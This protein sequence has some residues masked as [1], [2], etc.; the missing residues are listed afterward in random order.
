[1][2]PTFSRQA[3]LADNARKALHSHTS[4]DHRKIGVD[5]GSGDSGKT[6]S[7]KDLPSFKRTESGRI[8][9]KRNSLAQAFTMGEEHDETENLEMTKGFQKQLDHIAHEEKYLLK[10]GSFYTQ[11]W[12][13]LMIVALIYTA[14]VTPYEIALVEQDG[15]LL[16]ALF[17]TNRLVDFTFLVDMF[18][19]LNLMFFN[20]KGLLVKS[21]RRIR[22]RYLTGWFGIDFI[23]ILP[24]DLMTLN[25]TEEL[26][27]L[28]FLRIFRLLKLLRIL[29]ASRLF[30]DA[31][32]RFGFSTAVTTVFQLMLTLTLLNHWLACIWGMSAMLQPQHVSTWLTVWLDSQERKLPDCQKDS[33]YANAAYRNT[34]RGAHNTPCRQIHSTL[35]TYFIWLICHARAHAYK[36]RQDCHTL[37]RA[38]TEP[39][40]YRLTANVSDIPRDNPN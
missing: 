15:P 6:A 3:S 17:V 10:P 19:S 38:H 5:D 24:Y 9:G 7:I 11:H 40:T 35:S 22:H 29:R 25:S 32:T 30:K 21:R 28:R 16:G 12:D 34:D 33:P 1:M 31:H 36:W 18:I 39:L 27:M 26:G 20:E 2:P 4:N 23:T 37:A 14:L 8:G 13:H